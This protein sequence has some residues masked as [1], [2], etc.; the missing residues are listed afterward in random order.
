M[1]YDKC[2]KKGFD[3]DMKMNLTRARALLSITEED[4]LASLKKKYH[5][6]MSAC[7]SFEDDR[8]YFYMIPLLKSKL[9]KVKMRSRRGKVDFYFRLEPEAETYR[10][11]NRNL[12]IAELLGTN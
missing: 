9:A 7:L 8:L 1:R 10:I 3:Y 12:Q 4:D 5:R 2:K 6:L 11:P